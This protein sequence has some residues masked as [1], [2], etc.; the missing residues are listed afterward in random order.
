MTTAKLGD[1]FI[2]KHVYKNELY[3]F[4]VSFQYTMI[5]SHYTSTQIDSTKVLIIGEARSL[6]KSL[7]RSG[8]WVRV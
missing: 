8:S 1:T 6:W 7:I 4:R 2:L 3:R 5:V